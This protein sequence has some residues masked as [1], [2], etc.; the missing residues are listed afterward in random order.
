[1]RVSLYP[2]FF[3]LGHLMVASYISVCTVVFWDSCFQ[4]YVL[5]CPFIKVTGK[6]HLSQKRWVLGQV[7][8]S[9]KGL[10]EPRPQAGQV[11]FIA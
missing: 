3:Q 11:F 5:I 8:R 10:F 9:M 7:W 1:M 2:V 4:P 6:A